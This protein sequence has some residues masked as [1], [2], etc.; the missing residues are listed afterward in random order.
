MRRAAKIDANHTAIVQALRAV[1]AT[2]QSLAS[3]GKGCPDLL[4]G[5]RGNNVLLEVKDGDK[6]PSAR[7]LTPDEQEWHATWAG[8]VCIVESIDDALRVIGAVV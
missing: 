3:V 4:C 5:Y 8:Q 7:R 1:G 2:V 6:P